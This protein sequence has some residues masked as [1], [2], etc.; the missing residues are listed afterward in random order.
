M[1]LFNNH[2]SA[3]RKR[4]N[5]SGLLLV[6]L[7]FYYN[8]DPCDNFFEPFILLHHFRFSF[9]NSI[10]LINSDHLEKKNAPLLNNTN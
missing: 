2:N 10:P 5:V 9:Q 7:V 3:S 6:H 8:P 1:G 4:T